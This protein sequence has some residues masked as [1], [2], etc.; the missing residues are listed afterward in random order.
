MFPPQLITA[1]DH[2]G[3]AVPDLDEAIDFYRDNFGFGLVHEET[4][5]GH[6]HPA[7]RAGRS[8]DVFAARIDVREHGEQERNR[9]HQPRHDQEAES[10]WTEPVR[11][12]VDPPVHGHDL[13]DLRPDV[14]RANKARGREPRGTTR[15]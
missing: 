10:T 2:V 9:R 12:P 14:E 1:I 8:L 7:Q 6:E 13:T 3:I 5:D 4:N 15:S 11:S